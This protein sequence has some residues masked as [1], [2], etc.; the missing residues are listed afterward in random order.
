MTV[1]DEE[2]VSSETTFI[3]GVD[4]VGRGSLAGPVAAAAVVFQRG[5]YIPGIN[6]SKKLCPN[7]RLE[8]F[9]EIL[10][11]SV[12]TAV[13]YVDSFLIDKL[14][15]NNAVTLAVYRAITSLS[16]MPE[17]VLVDGFPIPEL[18]FSQTAI[19]GGDGLSHAIG[20][21][22]IVA[23]VLRDR[24]MEFYDIFFPV[25]GFAKNK[26]YGTAFHMKKIDDYG[27]C[28]IHRKSYYP[29]RRLFQ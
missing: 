19:I 22:S 11:Y 18:P 29:M 6:D 23:K 10:K 26:G 13:G 17:W 20:A 8:L 3:C 5:V 25:Y 24:V 12:S 14:G 28:R 21:A 16:V 27:F 9:P 4:E 2:W 1:N 7:K 15:I